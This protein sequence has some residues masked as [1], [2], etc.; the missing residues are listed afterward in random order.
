M[1]YIGIV[2]PSSM[3]TAWTTSSGSTR[4]ASL[5]RSW[6]TKFNSDPESTKAFTW[7]QL[8]S[9]RHISMS[10]LRQVL[11]SFDD[12]ATTRAPRAGLLPTCLGPVIAGP[13]NC[14]EL[15]Q[16]VAICFRLPQLKQRLSFLHRS[17]SAG[18]KV[19]L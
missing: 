11:V 14:V 18:N 10:K 8:P 5:T 19:V 2:L 1:P 7:C 15:G 6:A 4:P 13:L 17:L 3:H 12:S 16:F 9:S